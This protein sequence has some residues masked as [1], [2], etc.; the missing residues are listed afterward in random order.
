MLELHA[1]GWVQRQMAQASAAAARGT[2]KAAQAER[3]VRE[4][5]DELGKLTLVCMAM[6]SLLKE[7]IGLSEEELM[8]RVKELDLQ[9]GRADGKVSHSV[10]ECPRCG[11]AMSSRHKRCLYCGEEKLTG[12]AFE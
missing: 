3:R 2:S 11:R 5:E 9:D 7:R 8:E 12:S 4:L 1:W 10:L 6:W